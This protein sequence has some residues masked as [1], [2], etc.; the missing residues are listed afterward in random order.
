MIPYGRQTI[1]DDDVAAV[2][3]ALRSDFLTQGPVIAEF[4]RAFAAQ[5]GA[6]HAVAVCNATAALH[7]ALRVAG[8]GPGHRVFTSPITFLASAN[9]AAYV[10][11]T[12]DFADIDPRSVTLDPVALADA[13]RD[14]TRAVVAVDYAGQAADL[15]AL[16]K[17]ARERGAVLIDDAS[18]ATGGAFHT[19]GSPERHRLGGNP[20]ADLTV[21]SFHPV[22]T[23]TTGEGG[24]LVT[25]RD[26]FATLARDLRSH[27]LVRDP[28]R[29]LAPDDSAPLL[30]ER[31]PWFYEMQDLGWN[32]RITDLQA[33][34]GLSQLKRLPETLRRRREIVAA[35]NEAFADLPWLRTPGLREARDVGTTSWHLYSARVDFA[36]LGKTRTRVMA[37]LRDA[38]VGSQVL[39]IP[40][41][42]Q[43]W[44]R[45]TYGYAQG[46]CPAA[47]AFYASALS[48]PLFPAMS[49]ADIARVIAA[50]RALAPAASAS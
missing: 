33:A 36:A 49:D 11:A 1:T 46:K 15:P 12:P 44:Y 30:A 25:N 37:E 47:E 17:L 28:A 48:L 13:W 24:M 40:V 20:W 3:A 18:H 41:Y 27:G 10:G 26:D 38:G 39:Y 34:L 2:V 32:Y 23:L 9:C 6:R 8:V 22:K 21:F 19:A 50:V 14:D 31:G 4:E 43:P 35:Y 7:L 42:L 45:R 16:S 29:F 5:V